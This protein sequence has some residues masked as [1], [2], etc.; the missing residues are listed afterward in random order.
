MWTPLVKV[1]HLR[2]VPG[3]LVGE[4]GAVAAGLLVGPLAGEEDRHVDLVDEGDRRERVGDLRAVVAVALD[5]AEQ[6]DSLGVQVLVGGAD[7]VAVLDPLIGPGLA[8]GRRGGQRVVDAVLGP[9]EGEAGVEDAARVERRLGV[10]DHRERGDRGEAGRPGGADEELAD[11]AVGDARHRHLVVEDPGLAGDRLDRV[12][13]VEALERLEVVEGAA[14]AAGAAHVDVDDG[15]AELLNQR[16]N[17][18]LAA[19]RVGIAVAGVLEQGR[20]RTAAPAGS[21]TLIASCV[22]SRVVR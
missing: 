9:G 16:L 6:V 14:R 22:P 12:V 18:A 5:L 13:A 15:E 1:N 17:R 2:L 20:V 4:V 11:P 3:E 8:A 7:R 10:V 21:V 19:V